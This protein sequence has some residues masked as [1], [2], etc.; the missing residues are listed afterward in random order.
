MKVFLEKIS[1]KL[2]IQEERLLFLKVDFMYQVGVL[3]RIKVEDGVSYYLYVLI[4]LR[5]WFMGVVDVL[6]ILDLSFFS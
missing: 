1:C 5:G 3:V 4:L 6:G 2:V